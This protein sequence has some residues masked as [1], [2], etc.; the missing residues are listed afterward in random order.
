MEGQFKLEP[1]PVK[2]SDPQQSKRSSLNQPLERN[3][4]LIRHF[5]TVGQYSPGSIYG[6]GEELEDRL[7]I[8]KSKVQVLLLP[9]YW[10]FQKEQN[11]GNIWSRTL[12]FLD[13]NIPSREGLFKEFLINRRW[14]CYREKVIERTP[15]R[16]VHKTTKRNIPIV[17]R[18]EHGL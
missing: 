5:I 13:A 10:L 6:L 3:V 11:L 18:I 14:K 16:I 15:K 7:I 12:M 1:L 2:P 8:A 17:C 4:K 9:R